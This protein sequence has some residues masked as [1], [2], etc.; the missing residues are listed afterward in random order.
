MIKRKIEETKP[1]DIITYQGREYVRMVSRAFIIHNKDGD[2]I[3]QKGEVVEV[4]WPH[5]TSMAFEAARNIRSMLSL[6]DAGIR[7]VDNTVELDYFNDQD[8]K[9]AQDWLNTEQEKGNYLG[10][11]V[12]STQT[13][14]LT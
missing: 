9:I 8:L 12:V 7:A 1:G 14:N 4:E 3:L 2:L 10:V 11:V 6:T 13:N 5:A